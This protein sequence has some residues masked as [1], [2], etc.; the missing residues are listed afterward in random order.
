MKKEGKARE[1]KKDTA[2]GPPLWA[3][4]LPCGLSLAAIVI[5]VTKIILR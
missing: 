3:W 2:D 1:H 5:S 4:L